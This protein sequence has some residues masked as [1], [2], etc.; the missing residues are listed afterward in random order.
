MSSDK[1]IVI[2]FTVHASRQAL[3]QRNHKGDGSFP[4]FPLS[5]NTHQKL[6]NSKDSY[7]RMLCW[8]DISPLLIKLAYLSPKKLHIPATLPTAS[9]CASCLQ[10]LHSGTHL[11]D[12]HGECDRGCPSSGSKYCLSRQKLS[13]NPSL[14]HCLEMSTEAFKLWNT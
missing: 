8:A 10:N 14:T 9:A 7:L 1:L 13:G 5:Y 12:C 2:C 4:H 11:V 6:Y 3:P